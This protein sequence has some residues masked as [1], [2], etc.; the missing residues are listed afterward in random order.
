M[1]EYM[2]LSALGSDST[3]RLA[4][5]S[6]SQPVRLESGENISPEKGCIAPKSWRLEDNFTPVLGTPHAHKRWD[7]DSL[8]RMDQHIFVGTGI[9]VAVCW[10]Q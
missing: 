3:Q 4:L 8:I 6:E 9:K 5:E 10:Q 1:S 2:H 7:P